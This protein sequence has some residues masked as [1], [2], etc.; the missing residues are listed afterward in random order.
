MVN[1]VI[2]IVSLILGAWQHKANDGSWKSIEN[3]PS[4]LNPFLANSTTY[5]RFLPYS[6]WNGNISFT[7]AA[8]QAVRADSDELGLPFHDL[9]KNVLRAL[10]E[11][12]RKILS[13]LL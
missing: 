10:D 13:S 3:N 4:P 1:F 9:P 8:F 7:I 12:G 5:Y 11:V 6:N 2:E